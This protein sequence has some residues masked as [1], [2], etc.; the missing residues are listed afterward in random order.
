MKTSISSQSKR[1]LRLSFQHPRWILLSLVYTGACYA[2]NQHAGL[3]DID[4]PLWIL[5]VACLLLLSPIYHGLLILGVIEGVVAKTERISVFVAVCGAFPGLVLGEL[6][7]AAAVMVGSLLFLL[8]GIYIGIRLVYYKQALLID[9]RSLWEAFRESFR[10]TAGGRQAACLLGCLAVFYG[11]GIG[12]DWLLVATA[13]SWLLH[14]VTVSISAF[15]LT[16]INVLFTLL[17]VA[18]LQ[19]A[20]TVDDRGSD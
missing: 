12:I 16:W 11:V 1:A 14:P 4:D 6:L 15:L 9:R 2:A 19:L 17:F 18:D 10:R 8:P 13:P 7:T 5:T 3:F 20:P